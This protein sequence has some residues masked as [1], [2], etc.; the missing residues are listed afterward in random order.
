MP[1][2]DKPLCGEM[3]LKSLICSRG[4][5]VAAIKVDKIKTADILTTLKG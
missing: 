1:K 2:R 4:E 5:T 3:G